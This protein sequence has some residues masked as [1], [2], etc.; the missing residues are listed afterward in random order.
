MTRKS[1]HWVPLYEGINT[2][3][4]VADLPDHGTRLFYIMLLTKFDDWGRCTADERTLNA[5]VWPMLRMSD[6]QTLAA[7]K[8][9]RKVGL[10]EVYEHDGETF[11]VN[12]EH[13][14]KAGRVGKRDHRRESDFPDP[15]ASAVVGP[16]WP[17]LARTGP[18]PS[19]P[20]PRRPS[21]VGAHTP[22][23]ASGLGSSGLGSVSV[24][25]LGSSGGED[26]VSGTAPDQEPTP[27]QAAAAPP[28]VPAPRK[29]PTGPNAELIQHWEVEW[30]ATRGTPYAVE[31]KDGVAAAAILKLANGDV[32]EARRRAD[33][34]LHSPDAWMSQ[35]ASLS[36]LRARWNQLAVVVHGNEHEPKGA[37][38]LREYEAMA[39]SRANPLETGGRQ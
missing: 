19:Q 20:G 24:S 18:S 9:C 11:I 30:L 5:I 27:V 32:T 33:R 22:P 29:P 15:S 4:R 39:E 8:A 10:L 31:A 34:L 2:S 7:I 37:R 23:H 38:G 14:V 26:S 13:E 25:D 35:N 6:E 12:V 21:R 17:E 1:D 16:D 3:R 28:R 36:L